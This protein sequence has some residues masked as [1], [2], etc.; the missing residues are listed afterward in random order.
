MNKNKKSI[1][2]ILAYSAIAVMGVLSSVSMTSAVNELNRARRYEAHMQGRYLAEAAASV[3]ALEVRSRLVD[4]EEMPSGSQAV[5]FPDVTDYVLSY[6]VS[7]LDENEVS[8]VDYHGIVR[9]VR[10]FLVSANAQHVNYDVSVTSNII[11]SSSR[12]YAFQHAV[13]YDSDLEMLPGSAMTLSGKIHS[14]RD[15]Y[16]DSDGSTLT[17]DSE[18]MYAFGDIYNF[19]KNNGAQLSGTVLVKVTGTGTYQAMDRGAYDLDSNYVNWV[20]ESQSVWGGTV[21]SGD[22]GVQRLETIEVGDINPGGYYDNNADLRIID[23]VI[24]SGG[25]VVSIPGAVSET[26][27]YNVREGKIVTVTDIDMGVINASGYFPSNGLLYATRSDATS[28]SPNSIRIKNGAEISDGLTLVTNNPLYIQGD[29]NS[30]NKKPAAVI[31]DAVNILSNNWNDV[32][33]DSSWDSFSGKVASNTTV[34]TAFIAGGNPTPDGGGIY[35]GGLENYPRLHENWSGKQLNIRG[36]FV[37]IWDSQIAQGNWAYGSPQYTAPGRNWYY[38]TD[39][40]SE[41]NL[42]PFTPFVVRVARE[43]GWIVTN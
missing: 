27:I 5:T 12:M 16:L 22:H 4:G 11:F 24:Y 30:T 9:K 21:K 38:D 39:F 26:T 28:S 34:N 2:L 40:N 42:P 32:N 23:G 15:I 18:Y 25:S 17:I 13:F 33:G 14:N 36:S 41:S 31:C 10:H 20:S 29:Y 37:N 7:M 35:S 3:A 43:V 8:L 19:R 6:E 1:A